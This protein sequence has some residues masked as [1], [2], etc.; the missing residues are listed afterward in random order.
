YYGI[1]IIPI[2]WVVLY[3]L[4]GT[5]VDVKRLYRTY[6]LT[7]TFLG[8]LIGSTVIFF[9]F[10]LDDSIQGYVKY[11][12]LF[13][14]LFSIQFFLTLLFRILFVSI[15]VYRIHSRKD[16]FKTILLGGSEKAVK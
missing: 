3:A 15:Q 4:Q 7:L 12:K 1:V 11:Y 8:V 6:T 9:V 10:L 2:A 5:Y 16:G 14:F 13:I